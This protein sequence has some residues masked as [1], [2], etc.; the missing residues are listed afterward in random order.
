[1]MFYLGEVGKR[2]FRQQMLMQGNLS[3]KCNVNR[4][5]YR[6]HERATGQTSN[7]TTNIVFF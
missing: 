7:V 6:Q 5:E 3:E 4:L 2:M 1:M